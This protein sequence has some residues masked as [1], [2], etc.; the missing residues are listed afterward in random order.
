MGKKIDTELC[1]QISCDYKKQW[2]IFKHES[3]FKNKTFKFT[4][5]L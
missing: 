5:T 1:K 3:V 2:F 4:Q